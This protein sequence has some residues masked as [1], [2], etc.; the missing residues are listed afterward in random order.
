LTRRIFTRTNCR[1]SRTR[2][3]QSRLI[4]RSRG[5]VRCRPERTRPCSEHG[6]PVHRRPARCRRW[7]AI[8]LASAASCRCQT[9][10]V[11]LPSV[12]AREE[13][14]GIAHGPVLLA[15]VDRITV[16]LRCVFAHPS[17]LHLL[18][19]L[20]SEG[21]V[22]ESHEEIVDG[23]LRRYYDLTDEGA[24]ILGEEARRL[25]RSAEVAVRALKL[26]GVTA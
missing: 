19:R 5:T 16:G 13:L 12:D 20:T 17:G 26:R 7:L 11:D 8:A 4:Q 22:R 1:A 25:Q 24:R 6:L 2:A 15:S 10:W 9:G 21:L 3:Y 18:D 23:R 14:G